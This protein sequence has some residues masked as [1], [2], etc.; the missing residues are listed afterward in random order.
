MINYFGGTRRL[1]FLI[2]LFF[3][4]LALGISTFTLIGWILGSIVLTSFGSGL[5]PMAPSTA[6]LFILFCGAILLCTQFPKVLWSYKVG[7]I[8]SS[9]G[10]LIALLFFFLSSFGIRLAIEHLG[11]NIEGSINGAPYG[12]ISPLTAL[13]FVFAGLSFLISILLFKKQK[14]I[15]ASFTLAFLVIL[16]SI[17]LLLAHLFGI[18]LLYGTQFIPPA[19]S[20]SLAFFFLGIALIAFISPKIWQYKSEAD[21][22]S[23]GSSMILVMIF[24][25]LAAGIVSAGYFYYKHHENEFK[26][27]NEN[28]LSAVADLKISELTHIRKEW[29][30]DVSLFYKNIVFST[31]VDRYFKKPNDI[32]AY[33]QLRI[34]LNHFKVVNQYNNLCL[35]DDKGVERLNI[36]DLPKPHSSTIKNKFLEVIKSGKITF[37]DFYRNDYDQHIYL[38]ILVPIF[39]PK[40]SKRINGVLS[41]RI[42]PEEYLYPYIKK[43]PTR[44]KT[45][46]TM[47]VRKE[48]DYAVYLNE[49]KLK[50]NAALSF[51]IS[52]KNKNVLA[53]KALLGEEGIVEG[54]DYRNVYV[55]ADIHHIPDS[56]WFIITKMD[57]AEV[58]APLSE[59]LWLLIFLITALLFGSGSS[60]AVIWRHQRAR[61]YRERLQTAEA[62]RESYEL[63]EKVFSNTHI[64]MAYLDTEFNFIRVNNAYAEADEHTPDFYP[65][66]NHFALFPYEENEKIFRKVVEAGQP[67]IAFAKPFEYAEHPERGISYWDWSLQPVKAKDGSVSSLILSLIN[68]TDRVKSQI[69][70]QKLN[71]VYALLSNINQAIV[72]VHDVDQL[73]KEICRIGIE[74]GKFLMVWIGMINPQT[75]IVDVVASAGVTGNYFNK[76]KIDLSDSTQSETPTQKA[77]RSGKFIIS[78]DIANDESMLAKRDEAIKLGFKSLATFPIKVFGT[79][80]GVIKLYSNEV[81]FFTDDEIKLLDEM[82]M[83][84]SFALEFIEQDTKRKKAEEFLLKFRMGIERSGDAVFLTDPDGTIV[85]V[86]PAFEN[87]FGYTKEEAIGKTPRILKSGT[88]N[89]EYYKNFWNDLLTKRPVIHEIVNKTKDGRLLSFEAS[90]NPIINEQGEII[91]HLA[92]ERDIT[93]RKIAEQALSESENRFRSLYENSTIGIY[94]TTPDGMILLANPTLVNMLGYLSFEDLATRNLEKDGFEPTYERKQF[95]EQIESQNEVKGLESA[96]ICKDGSVIFIRE[97]ARAIREA[98]GKIL[99][100][101]GTV[102]DITER[103]RVE[104]TLRESEDRF[105][106]LVENSSDLICTHD[107]DGNILSVNRAALQITGYSEEEVLKMNMQ[108]ILVPEYKRVFKAY[109]TKIFAT[110]KAQGFM[111]IQTKTGERRIWEYNNTLRTKGVA[112]PI[113]RGMVKDITEQKRAEE[114][115]KML[116]F[117]MRSVNE[118]V[119][120]TDMEDK[121]IFVNESFKKTYGYNEDELIGQN[122]LIIRSPNNLPEVVREILPATIRGGWTG[123]ILNRKKDGSEFPIFLSTTII[124]DK[125]NKPIALIG[126]AKDITERKRTEQEIISQK[127]RF[128]QLL[129]NSP[130]AIALLDDKD[131]VVHVNESFSKMFG[132]LPEE[133]KGRIINEVIVSSELQSEAKN[134][135]DITH[136]GNQINKE[137]YR[138]KKDGTLIYVQIIGVPIIENNMTVGIYGMYVDLTQRKDAEEK[139][140]LAKELAEQS[141]KLKSEFLAQMSHEIRTPINIIVGNIDYLNESL[142][143]QIDDEARD[144]F[145]GIDLASKRII[146]TVDLILNVAELQTSG[147]K[148]KFIKLDLNSGLLNNLYLEHQQFA[149]QKG[150][151]LIYKCDFKETKVLADDEYSVTQIFANLIDNAIKYTK[152]G[153]VEILLTKNKSGNVTVEVKDTGI[154]MS[155]EFLPKI[156]EPFVQEEQGY[157]RSYEGNGLGLALTKR[158]CDINNAIIEVES[159]KNVGSTFRV[160]FSRG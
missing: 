142:G 117:A 51:R 122:M 37:I 15:L 72:R 77:I 41:L 91:G 33:R 50:Q 130:I 101:D 31:L 147:Y 16:V 134:Y 158:Y 12:H 84:I 110:G 1:P 80:K 102:E 27:E 105:R 55:L 47:L 56:P 143:K 20:T 100:Y 155:K 140:K 141:D 62:L 79:A 2:T 60:V 125:A 70:I 6:F 54:Y 57:F 137:S 115:I 114:E 24:V 29:V 3:G 121:I 90:V 154:G 34:W 126:V 18:P 120:I 9:I 131:R 74:D 11:F 149:K 36:A 86:N 157:S 32:E 88:L 30:E 113:V 89:Q 93:E 46:E 109:L 98:N 78:N 119:S 7:I 145:D 148:P 146:R 139:M 26:L 14:L 67:Y 129:E 73:F 123:E 160:I 71:R 68:V 64:M 59:R 28:E 63:L 8:I 152:S 124:R 10:I 52:L 58:Y 150:L 112:E 83:D 135:S 65:G 156:F 17:I 40:N 116:A 38:N 48:G 127:N 144:C 35:H 23:T 92:I 49:L 128:E 75:K 81:E 132:Y 13:C 111:T 22:A 76:I 61:F 66:K 153:K 103:K 99:Y 69:H 108:D 21:A 82:A 118:C 39:D 159:E 136:A 53:V 133:I 138:Q 43:W 94:R 45:S 151:E 85:Y 95:L 42:D 96:W 104:E 5:I 97:S 44:S 25:A 4:Y 106:D 87:I 107:L 19:L